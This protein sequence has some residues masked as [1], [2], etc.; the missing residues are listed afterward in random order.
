MNS[1]LITIYIYI[2][3]IKLNGNEEEV[4]NIVTYSGLE[5]KVNRILLDVVDQPV[6]H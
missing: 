1:R 2:G 3:C 5:E 6:I 4:K